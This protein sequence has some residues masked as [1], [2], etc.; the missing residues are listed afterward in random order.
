[1]LKMK[2]PKG[3]VRY[4]SAAEITSGIVKRVTFRSVAYTTILLILMSTLTYLLT[5]RK[6]IDSTVLRTPGMLHQD[7]GNGMISN[8]YNFEVVNKTFYGKHIEIKVTKPS[9]AVLKMVDRNSPQFELNE[10]ELVKGSFFIIIPQT[11][12]KA[13]NIKTEIEIYSNNK[14]I[15]TIETNFVGP[16]K[17]AL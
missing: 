14:L 13:N 9:T 3:L 6:E 16:V 4:A 11:D 10:D 8:M 17:Q 7:Q 12:I 2:K 5:T 1:M 15:Q